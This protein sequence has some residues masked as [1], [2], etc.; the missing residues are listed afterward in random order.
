MLSLTNLLKKLFFDIFL[1]SRQRQ[2]KKFLY[3]F[4]KSVSYDNILCKTCKDPFKSLRK[5]FFVSVSTNL[6]WSRQNYP[7]KKICFIIYLLCIYIM[8]MGVYIIFE[9]KYKIFEKK[10]QKNS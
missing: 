2:K 4:V 10:S 6:D 8:Y 5:F 7:K 3:F 9:Y 1:T